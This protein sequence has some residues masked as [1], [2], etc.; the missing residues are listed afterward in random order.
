[1]AEKYGTPLE[2]VSQ[3]RPSVAETLRPLWITTVE[4]L[5]STAYE[6]KGRQGLADLLSMAP[7]DVEAMAHDLLPLLPDEIRQQIPMP[8]Q[9]YGL[10]ALD[11]L[12]RDRP[13]DF[14]LG[15]A[16]PQV[17]P[18]RV[19]LVDRMPAIRNQGARGTCVAHACT[20]VREFM[21]GEVVVDLSEQFLYW[22]ARKK[23]V[24]PI[25]QNRDGLLLVYG[26]RA[27]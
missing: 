21:T 17:L 19:S 22:V 2:K 8:R 1:M 18:E 26:M 4:E 7:S 25:L 12:A 16:L 9:A 15:L 20:A 6:D 10:G 5:V 23:L 13:R 11:K 14:G 24:T 27:L 3:L